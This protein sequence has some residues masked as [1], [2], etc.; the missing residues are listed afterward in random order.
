MIWLLICINSI[1][2]LVLI[3][4]VAK[5]IYWRTNWYKDIDKRVIEMLHEEAEVD[6]IYF[7]L[8]KKWFDDNKGAVLT[9]ENKKQ[10][11]SVAHG[12]VFGLF[13]NGY[14]DEKTVEPGKE[15]EPRKV[16]TLLDAYYLIE[17][18]SIIKSEVYTARGFPM[19][20]EERDEAIGALIKE[21]HGL[22]IMDAEKRE[23]RRRFGDESVSLL[24]NADLRYY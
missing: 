6:K 22:E 14:Q 23:I 7:D 18:Y 24:K 13:P 9:E 5:A 3:Y 1:L 17:A 12:T 11:K 15:K 2:L 19:V 16:L 8:V 10:L 21:W 20:E 4:F